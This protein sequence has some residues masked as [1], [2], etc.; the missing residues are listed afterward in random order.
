MREK[1]YICTLGDVL[2]IQKKKSAHVPHTGLESAVR[3]KVSTIWFITTI[4]TIP[5]Y[6]YTICQKSKNCSERSGKNEKDWRTLG[7][8]LRAGLSVSSFR[9]IQ[10]CRVAYQSTAPQVKP[11]AAAAAATKYSAGQTLHGYTV[12]KVWTMSVLKQV[13]TRKFRGNNTETSCYCEL[14]IQQYTAHYH[15]VSIFQPYI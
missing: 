10:G 15:M 11:D 2:N 12:Q 13:V 8:S 14:S 7:K 3:L 5:I 1:S 4:S 6:P 9:L